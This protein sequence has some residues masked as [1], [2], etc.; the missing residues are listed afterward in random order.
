MLRFLTAGEAHGQSLTIIIEGLPAGLKIEIEELNQGLREQ[1]IEYGSQ[2]WPLLNYDEVTITSG[3]RKGIT[4]ASPLC[5]TIINKDWKNW[6]QVMAVPQEETVSNW[7]ETM[8]VP[9]PGQADLC[10]AIK[11]Q[12]KDLRNVIERANLRQTSSQ[13]IAGA[14]AKVLLKE[15]NI[16]L[17]SHIVEINGI[18]ANL[19]DER[20]DYIRERT[21][22]SLLRCGDK[23]AEVRMIKAIDEAK[24]NGNSLGGIFEVKAINLPPGL[25]SYV[26]WDRQLDGRLAQALMSI[27]GVKGVE[28]GLGFDSARRL[29]SQAYDAIYYSQRKGFYRQTNH[30][31]GLEFGVT[32]GQPLCLRAAVAP[33][34]SLSSTLPS[35]NFQTKEQALVSYERADICV[36]PSMSV[37]GEA[38]VAIEL[39]GAMQEKFGGDSLNEMK[40]N[41][42][43]YMSYL[44]NL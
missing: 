26:H 4:L 33:G 10:G 5:L 11:Y 28:L 31:G 43:G 29:G 13:V 40:D 41:Y 16:L 36:V 6:Q 14:V 44:R 39:A 30:A 35:V 42:Q 1:Q 37:V 2:R 23:E 17:L 9:R 25:G 15:F 19:A 18:K 7:E 12:Y 22:M 24:K 20:F 8:M 3:L 38:V 27:P 21:L 34:P 32:N